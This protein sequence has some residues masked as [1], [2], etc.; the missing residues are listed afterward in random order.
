MQDFAT[1][2]IITVR[3]KMQLLETAVF[4]RI[5][6]CTQLKRVM[7]LTG[8][9]ILIA[10]LHV[11][12]NGITQT[13]NLSF[14]NAPLET[15]LK[16]IEKQTGYTFF[17]RTNWV[18]QAKK[19]T[20]KASNLSLQ[21]ALDLCFKEQPVVYAISGKI[22]TITPK[23]E[24]KSEDKGNIKQNSSL[25]DNDVK[26]KVVNENGIPIEGVNVLVKGTDKGTTTDKEGDF[27]LKGIDEN[28]VLVI[29]SIGYDKQEFFLK[30]KTF[31]TFQLKVSSVNLDEV[32][33]IGYGQTTKRLNTGNVSTVKSVDIEKQPVNNPLLA[34]AGRVT[35]MELTQ[36]NGLPGS[37][38]LIRIR[39][40]NTIASGYAPLFIIDG[41]PYPSDN[42]QSNLSNI[43]GYSFTQTG[44]PFFY[45]NPS[46]I[47]SI[48]VLKDADAT[49]IYGSRGANGVILI[50]TKKGR[51]GAPRINI[52][53][54]SGV[55]KIARKMHLMNPRQYLDMRYEA[56]KND[57]ALPNPNIDYDLTLWDT[58]R[59]T[60]WQKELIGGTAKYNDYQA[61]VSGG[62]S[63]TQILVGT[64][65]H[66]ETTVFPGDFGSQKGSVN[67]NINNITPNKK[68]KL[69]LS[70]MYIIT[71][72]RLI[73]N[74]LTQAAITLPPI[75]PAM[76]NDDGTINWE[77][78]N[79]GVGTWPIQ[80][81]AT[82]LLLGYSSKTN[83]LVS[84]AT[85]SYQVLSDLE[86]K[87][88]LGYTLTQT[89]EILKFPLTSFDPSMWQTSQRASRFSNGSNTNWI[90][91][92][93]LLYSRHILN[94]DLRIL[95]G[96]TL[97]KNTSVSQ[98]LTAMGFNS[99]LLLEDIRSATTI[100]AD[101][102][103][104]NIY[105]YGAV[106]GRL[107]YNWQNRYLVNFTARRD[108]SSRFGPANRF[109]N[110][111]AVG[112]GWVFTNEPK[113]KVPFISFGKIRAS[114]GTTG[115]DQ[116]GDYSFL[117]LY[118]SSNT[119]VPYMGVVPIS[120]SRIYTPDLAWEET[121]KIETGI[122][123]GFLKDKL[124]L[125]VS[126]YENRS[127]NQL[128]SY[129]LPAVTGFTTIRKNLNALIENKGL[130]IELRSQNITSKDF[131]W[132]S[133][134]NI[135]MNRNKLVSYNGS[136]VQSY[137]S[138]IGHPLLSYFVYNYL[139]V[140]A[141]TG[142]YV[143]ADSH[144]TPTINPNPNTDLTHLV[145]VTPKFFGGLQNNISYKSL[146]LDF[147][148]Q[149]VG[150]KKERLYLDTYI[151]GTFGYNQ[152]VWAL[153]RWK[154][155]GD[156][157]AY[158]RFSQN[159]SL[160]KVWANA[161]DSDRSYGD[162]SYVKLN[163]LSLSWLIPKNIIEKAH[164]QR[165]RLFIQGQNL[166][167]IT[168]Y[169]GLDPEAGSSSTSLPPLRVVTIGIQLMF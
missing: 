166:L 100:T 103:S 73:G 157:R 132:T 107:N 84:N 43:L 54:Q 152:P 113:I 63:N 76:Y 66:K 7:K 145:D 38:V 150:G 15:V 134:F 32:Q 52:N 40:V 124:F 71:D 9:L 101:Y 41:V 22:I 12:A 130:E 4:H 118:Q 142:T 53:I 2:A 30:G 8:L 16:D 47:E 164:V 111:G 149:F 78:N 143:V 48:D 104:N 59:Y 141:I 37:G 23:S 55:G 64:G 161:N 46:D 69:S 168:S 83:N 169:K 18:K 20:V 13:I 110:F 5:N 112:L 36:K 79:R 122:E 154:T 137:L 126:L 85:I 39:G 162:A 33:I 90:A 62:S 155:A 98:G 70:G 144:G 148:F 133:S 31:I 156:V 68:F 116:V 127:G 146:Q 165:A 17:Y 51:A 139:G 44:N 49:A 58:T 138:K 24:S 60:D 81:P 35:G 131:R 6:A 45:I 159:G 128:T 67:F 56:F 88:S 21:Q 97:Q 34:L 117:D 72:S 129:P 95:A 91:E 121:K 27:L 99:D 102:A 74:D 96:A 77:P 125:L 115:S 93:Q 1:L 158:Q 108:G 42:V 25:L 19:V 114:Y 80:N 106:F 136:E 105:R 10:C 29:S 89:N 57:G 82:S 87:T 151:P 14:E 26:G 86:F 94:G 153:N 140:D 50:T 92:P 160:S 11:S 75:A 120:T 123:L 28:A 167:T 3:R 163:N 119:G 135:S 61:S 147:S 65:Y 109:H